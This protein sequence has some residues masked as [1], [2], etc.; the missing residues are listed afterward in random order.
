MPISSPN[1]LA[2]VFSIS[3]E[4]GMLKNN[5]RFAIEKKKQSVNVYT[6]TIGTL[7]ISK[8]QRLIS[9]LVYILCDLNP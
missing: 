5:L 3:S 2:L 9:Y 6:R 8:Q 4:I 1:C 7:Q